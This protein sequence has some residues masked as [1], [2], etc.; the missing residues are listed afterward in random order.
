MAPYYLILDTRD[1]RQSADV[2]K[3][4]LAAIQ[5][6]TGEAELMQADEE[7][8]LEKYDDFIP[9]DLLRVAFATD[10]LDLLSLRSAFWAASCM[11]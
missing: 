3:A 10:R 11:I 9:S 5:A 8:R 2:V 4:V 1:P 6:A 7:P